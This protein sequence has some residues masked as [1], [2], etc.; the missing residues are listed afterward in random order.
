VLDCQPG[1]I[2]EYV[3]E[4]EG[5]GGVWIIKNSSSKTGK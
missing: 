3:N 1:E 5:L 2:L 4:K